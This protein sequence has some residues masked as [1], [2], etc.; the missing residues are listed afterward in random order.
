MLNGASQPTQMLQKIN[1]LK[2]V[3]AG[4]NPQDV[5]NYLLQ[6]NP[7]F[8]KFVE[9]NQG[10]TIEDIALSYDIDLNLIKQ[11]M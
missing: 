5:Y 8:K 9:D 3:L 11:F 7:E 2:N 6:T 10:K 4:K 1:M